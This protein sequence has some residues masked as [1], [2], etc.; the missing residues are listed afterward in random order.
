MAKGK[1]RGVYPRKRREGQYWAYRFKVQG[2]QYSGTTDLKVTASNLAAA[3][4]AMEKHKAQ[5]SAGKT[6]SSVTVTLRDAAKQF[7]VW[8]ESEHREHPNTARRQKVSLNVLQEFFGGDKTLRSITAGDLDDFSAWRRENLIKDVTI[9]HDLHALSQMLQYAER[10]KWVAGNVV[11]Q[12]RVPSDSASRNERILSS[13]EES[14]YFRVATPGTVLYDLCKL[15]RLQGL[16]P[17]EALALSKQ[18]IDLEGRTVSVRRSLDPSGRPV[19]TKSKAGK[20]ELDLA[21]EAVVILGRRIGG[22]SPWMFP[23]KKPGRPYTYSALVGCHDRILEKIGF[24]FDIYTFR[25]TFATEFYRHT[26]DLELLRKV[27]GHADLKTVQRY[28]HLSQ[29]DVSDALKSFHQA[30]A[31]LRRAP[32]A[33][34]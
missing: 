14:L 26:R 7:I 8:S 25:H 19:L 17:G 20:R 2:R 27:L 1:V 15:M 28:V 34:H 11:R 30:Q 29:Q 5:V 3:A 33:V 13:D 32:A 9:R 10:H 6:V 16:R 31:K 22:R 21:D 12:T 24:G 4:A 18:D 23:G